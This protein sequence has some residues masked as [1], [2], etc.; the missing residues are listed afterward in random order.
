MPEDKITTTTKEDSTLA[1][2]AAEMLKPKMGMGLGA[3]RRAVA[4][5]LADVKP[6]ECPNRLGIVFD[7]SGSMSGQPMTDAHSAVTNFLS[8][9]SAFETSVAVYPMNAESK[10]LTN[11]YALVT[12][13]VNGIQATGGTPLYSTLS[14]MLESEKLTRAIVFSDGKPNNGDSYLHRDEVISI[15]KGREVPVDT[16]F[17]GLKGST[18]YK[19]LEQLAKDTGGIFVWFED[20]TSL[21]RS[22]KYLSPG[23][24]GLL[25]NP[26]VKARIEKG[27][28]I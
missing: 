17:I 11:N 16:V 6:E 8:T 26:D 24:R 28:Q 15:S 18:G 14:E 25:S 12:M 7:D 5:R 4:A 21:S 1:R 9:C 3:K 10:P 22:L 27:E 19:E 20:S 13:Y 23:L 2:S